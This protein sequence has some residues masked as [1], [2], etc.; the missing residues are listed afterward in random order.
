MP[1]LGEKRPRRGLSSDG[2]STSPGTETGRDGPTYE[3]KTGTARRPCG[4]PLHPLPL[5]WSLS[6]RLCGGQP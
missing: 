4:C 6:V 1:L 5:V 3:K 2:N